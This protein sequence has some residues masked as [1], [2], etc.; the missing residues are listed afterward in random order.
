LFFGLRH[1][2]FDGPLAPRHIDATIAKLEVET[3][4]KAA[5]AKTD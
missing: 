5:A 3:A 1:H 4:A 2:F